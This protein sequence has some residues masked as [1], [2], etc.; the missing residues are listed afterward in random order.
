V[1]FKLVYQTR[2]V[3]STLFAVHRRIPAE[4]R[5]LLQQELLSWRKADPATAVYLSAG[6]WTRLYP[7]TDKDYDIVREIW[8]QVGTGN[9]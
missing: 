3:P 1:N 7:A 2:A 8:T 4:Q 6:A 5:K 9:P